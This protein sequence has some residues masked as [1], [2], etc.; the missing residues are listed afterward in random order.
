ME[1]HLYKYKYHVPTFFT[2]L[3]KYRKRAFHYNYFKKARLYGIGWLNYE[4]G[5]YTIDY[6]FG[7]C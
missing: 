3:P 2:W 4:I 7:I 1:F 6:D 5:V